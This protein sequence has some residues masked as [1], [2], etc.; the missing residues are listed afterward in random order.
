M[1]DPQKRS[2]DL[3]DMMVNTQ[4]ATAETVPTGP[5]Y[6]LGSQEAETAT[7]GNGGKFPYT[8]PFYFA[9]TIIFPTGPP[10]YCGDG[11]VGSGYIIC[12]FWSIN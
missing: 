1:S 9:D 10:Y 3:E 7:A 4:K 8:F 6:Y 12:G 11:V 5:P 2:I